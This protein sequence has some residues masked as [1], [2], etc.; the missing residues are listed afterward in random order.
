MQPNDLAR[1][2]VTPFPNLPPKDNAMRVLIMGE[3]KAGKSTLIN[4]VARRAVMAKEMQGTGPIFLRTDAARAPRVV[5]HDIAHLRGLEFV[6]LACEQENPFSET[7]CALIAS[8]DLVIWVTIASQAWRLSEQLI[9]DRIA[10]IVTR[11]MI[12]AVSRADKLRSQTDVEKIAGR[13]HR[14]TDGRFE[15]IVFLSAPPHE[16]AQST[17][18][19]YAWKATS[20]Q[21]LYGLLMRAA[22]LTAQGAAAAGS[23]EDDDAPDTVAWAEGVQ[24]KLENVSARLPSAVVTGMILHD[25]G[26]VISPQQGHP[27][28]MK[29]SQ[30]CGLWSEAQT[31][32]AQ[33]QGGVRSDILS[34]VS[35]EGYYLIHHTDRLRRRTV[36]LFCGADMQTRIMA[37]TLF[38]PI[39]KMA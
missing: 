20:G 19:D 35:M 18:Q 38:M 5:T 28:L 8:A 7:E 30:M 34:E 37:R 29:L 16:I 33:R 21:K 23:G 32:L 2:N 10:K 4:A 14:D 3:V 39:S 9:C 26:K 24:Q 11:P 17:T 31:R 25:T 1:S 15:D 13:L 12:L 6:E 27:D 36:F 22:R